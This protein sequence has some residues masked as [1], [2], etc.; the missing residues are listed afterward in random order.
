[1]A[2]VSCTKAPENIPG[3]EGEFSDSPAFHACSSAFEKLVD[4]FR[5]VGEFGKV[6]LIVMT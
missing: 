5:V 1:M 6:V 3:E 4:P 2:R